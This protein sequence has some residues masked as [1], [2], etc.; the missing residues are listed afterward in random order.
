MSDYTEIKHTCNTHVLFHGDI[1]LWRIDTS[2][3]SLDF[4]FNILSLSVFRFNKRALA[5]IHTQTSQWA[6]RNHVTLLCTWRKSIE[7]VNSIIFVL[8]NWIVA[9]RIHHKFGRKTR[10]SLL[11]GSMNYDSNC[12]CVLQ[13]CDHLRVCN[14]SIQLLKSHKWLAPT[15]VHVYFWQKK[16]SHRADAKH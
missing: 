1:S 4:H 6:S 5:Y 14:K 10:F 7:F 9:C 13:L 12:S 8:F 2:N 16:T 3:L 11:S 15:L